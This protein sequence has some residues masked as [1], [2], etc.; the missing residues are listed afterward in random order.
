MKNETEIQFDD[1]VVFDD[2]N[3]DP[4]LLDLRFKLGRLRN[5]YQTEERSYEDLPEFISG[6]PRV[7]LVIIAKHSNPTGFKDIHRPTRN[8]VIAGAIKFT[9]EMINDYGANLSLSMQ[10]F[11]KRQNASVGNQ[12]K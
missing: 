9:D 7:L 6:I 11:K 5:Q 1:T 8:E 4:T 10:T 2:G 3:Y 12:P